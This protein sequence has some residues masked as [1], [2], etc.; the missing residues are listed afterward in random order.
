MKQSTT[1]PRRSDNRQNEVHVR[2]ALYRSAPD[3]FNYARFARIW[4]APGFSNRNDR[5]RK[6]PK[7]FRSGLTFVPQPLGGTA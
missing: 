1:D 7:P 3:T 2:A 4:L 5:I 6:H